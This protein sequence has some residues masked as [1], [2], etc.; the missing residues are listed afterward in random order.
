MSR[1]IRIE[2]CAVCPSRDHKGAF[3]RVAY[4]PVC[5]SV[6]RELPHTLVMSRRGYVS[7][8]ATFEIPEWCPL[9][10]YQEQAA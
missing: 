9:E 3:A 5:R 8:S 4:V 1:V 7:A 6:D 2:S 10:K